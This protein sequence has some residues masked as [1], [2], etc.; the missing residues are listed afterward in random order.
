MISQNNIPISQLYN[1]YFVVFSLQDPAGTYKGSKTVLGES[2]TGTITVN[3]A[4]TFNF[5]LT[6]AVSITC[7]NEAY[8]YSNGVITVTNINKAGDCLHD[9]L[10]QHSITLKSIDYDTS[11]DVITVNIKYSIL[12]ISF[13]LKHQ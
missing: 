12:E 7:N 6:G 8:T 2:F 10:S 4:S 11:A 5:L 9:E 13:P 3:D 1:K